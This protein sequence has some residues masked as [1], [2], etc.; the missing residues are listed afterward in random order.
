V[1]ANKVN[2][3]TR[4]KTVEQIIQAVFMCYGYVFGGYVR[5]IL[6]EQTP[7]DIDCVIPNSERMFWKLLL[8][9]FQGGLSIVK[10]N[11]YPDPAPYCYVTRNF[12]RIIVHDRYRDI[13]VDVC[14]ASVLKPD[15]DVNMLKMERDK[16]S[17]M[18]EAPTGLQ[19]PAILRNIALKQA[20]A[21]PTCT[22]LRLKK[23]RNRGWTIVNGG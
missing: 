2:K 5:D 11:D 4:E 1:V 21:L 12:H 15:F 18:R 3:L 17:V 7:R 6:S 9:H 16:I 20:E 13:Q 10:M 14:S 22:P 8:Q 19:L 23:M